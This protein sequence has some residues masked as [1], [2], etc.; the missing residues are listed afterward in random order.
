MKG[1]LLT[2]YYEIELHIYI[3]RIY[4][5]FKFPV[6]KLHILELIERYVS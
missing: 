1:L 5:D 2:Y 3:V 6:S 4:V